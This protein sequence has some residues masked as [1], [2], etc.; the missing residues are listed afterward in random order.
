VRRTLAAS[1]AWRSVLP[2]LLAAP[3]VALGLWWLVGLSLAPLRPLAAAVR[4]R[5]AEALQPLPEGGLPSEI[6]PLVGALNALLARLARTFETQ[7]AFVADA[8]H[9]LRSPLTALKLQLEVLRGARD[10]AE[11]AEA[12]AALA[13][14]VTRMQR[15]VEQ[16]LTLARAEP[17][18]AEA[19]LARVDL[20]WVVRQAVADAAGPASAT[21]ARVI[22]I[23]N[24]SAEPLVIDG[25]AA[26]LE[27]LLRN[28]ID[29]ALR[30]AGPSEGRVGAGLASDGRPMLT[31]ED[32]GPGIPPTERE[33]VFARFY[34]RDGQASPGSGLGLAIVRTIAERHQASVTLAD[35]PGGGLRVM[36]S[37]AAASARPSKGPITK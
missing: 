10:D 32:D 15:L 27:I 22:D 14:G 4:E 37:F 18:G 33:R 23:G 21:G 31:V 3:V 34:R 26:A 16:L 13:D 19:P 9:E 29:N 5:H 30:Y 12:R 24:G 6:S 7:R 20:R 28:L 1:A 2:L 8:A 25:D 35:A 11:R 36:T 17:G